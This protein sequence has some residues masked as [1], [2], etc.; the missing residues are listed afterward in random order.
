[1]WRASW[2]LA[3]CLASPLAV[4]ARMPVAFQVDAS[5]SAST[6]AQV[7]TLQITWEQY[8][9]LGIP[10]KM[11][12]VN[13]QTPGPELQFKQDDSVAVHVVN[14]SPFNTTMHFH[15][16]EMQGTPWSD[17]VPGVTQHLIAPGKR[18]TY[19]FKATQHGNYWY[20]SHARDQI[21]DG[22]YGSIF[23]HSR[24]RTNTPFHLISPT[25]GN[26][27]ALMA[28]EKSSKAIA[29]F[30]LMHITSQ[31]KWE[32]TLASG[33]EIPCY[34]RILFNGKGRV[35]CLA[36]DEMQANLTPP[37]KGDLALVPQSTLTD[38]GCFPPKV[39]AAFGGDMSHFNE[40]AIPHSVFYDCQ[41]TTNPV[42][43]FAVF[44]NSWVSFN[45]LG[46]TNFAT[47]AF[48]ID[49][50]DMW[51]YAVDG[52]YIVPLRVQAIPLS[53]GER[54]SVLV[55]PTKAGA[56]KIRYN[57]M[58]APQMIDGYA[59]LS[60]SGTN[61][62]TLD[63]SAPWVSISGNPLTP[64][65]VFY[66]DGDARPYPAEPIPASADELHILNMKLDGASYLWA[67]NST[68]F[69]PDEM[70]SRTPPFLFQRPEAH[71]DSN[72]TLATR[73]NTWVDLVLFA[74]MFPM[75]PHPIHKHGSKM[76]MIGS[77]TGKFKWASVDEAVKEVPDRFNLVDPPRRDTFA[78]L[79]ARG[80]T[81]WIVVRYH[82]TN[83]GAWLLHCHISNHMMG[84]MMMV[85]L[86][87]VDAWPTVPHD[88]ISP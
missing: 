58:S 48:S 84:G 23:I 88:Y 81:S 10:R 20:H 4:A 68:R 82:V 40:S 51:V 62:R 50:H 9:P 28:A 52:S 32:I 64:G 79:V 13:G 24:P 83:P 1:M 67:M 45:I 38:R 33:I 2:L 65:V 80:D 29:V 19:K 39:M 78:T 54:Y 35:Q 16:L 27:S 18:F 73:N 42:E 12:L 87:G 72:V 63:Q 41:N 36:A 3:A 77:G 11:L 31:E 60:V 46:S 26:V 69:Q 70:D 71:A 57:A 61:P 55:R 85:L 56:F 43:T 86:D 17:G 49:E 34:D 25:A 15:G 22:L 66:S 53:N 6:S 59:V 14:D 37:Q 76:Y 74:S 75:P 47:G 8:A 5:V 44:Q 30:D 7:F 21:E